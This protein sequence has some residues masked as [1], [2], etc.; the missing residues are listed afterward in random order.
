MEKTML[1]TLIYDIDATFKSLS[2]IIN[3]FGMTVVIWG[4]LAGLWQFFSQR[5]AFSDTSVFF[6]RAGRVRAVLGIYI[7]FGLELM[8][9]GDIIRTFIDPSLDDLF[10]LAVMV[11]VRTV[12][13]YFLSKEVREA[14]HDENVN[15]EGS[16]LA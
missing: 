10:I 13:S 6:Q 2:Y 3:F 9:A 11:V 7:L 1:D 12:I 15:E 4:F 5:L 14:R 16:R 8:I